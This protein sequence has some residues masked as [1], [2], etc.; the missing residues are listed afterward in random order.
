MPPLV[1][2]AAISG[3]AAAGTAVI[4]ARSQSGA[5]KRAIT[6]QERAAARAEQFERE[7]D[8]QNRADEDRRA[9]EDKRRFD[10]DQQNIMAEKAERD[11]RQ[12]YQDQRQAYE[13]RIRYGKMVR[14][15]QLLGQPAPDP[16]PAFSGG[17][18]Y[19]PPVTLGRAPVSQ[20]VMAAPSRANALVDTADP[21]FNPLAAQRVPLSA[22]SRRRY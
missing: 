12:A 8:A 9:A 21:L 10:I 1:A 11:A 4:G 2:A 5:S 22:L 13:D 19:A 16:L 3:L 14:L 7:Q 18:P 6:A 17:A 15:S 20:P